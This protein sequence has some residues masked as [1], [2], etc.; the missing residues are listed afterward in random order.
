MVVSSAFWLSTCPNTDSLVA[1]VVCLCKSIPLKPAAAA[2]DARPTV[3]DTAT[4]Y[5]VNPLASSVIP[6]SAAW[7]SSFDVNKSP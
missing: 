5:L 4:P 7:V 6:S 1:S 2:S 3:C